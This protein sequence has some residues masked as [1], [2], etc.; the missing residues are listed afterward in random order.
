MMPMKEPSLSR[1]AGAVFPPPKSPN[2]LVCLGR[3]VGGGGKASGA[4]ST[5]EPGQDESHSLRALTQE[6][7][8]QTLEH[9]RSG[10]RRRG[11]GGSRLL[12]QE[13]GAYIN[14]VK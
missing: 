1:G 9:I 4:E 13:A 2:R 7:V 14:V 5:E 11:R 12:Y 6:G 8:H 3:G 10:G